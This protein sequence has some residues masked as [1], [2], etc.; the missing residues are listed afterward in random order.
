MIFEEL[1]Q[2]LYPELLENYSQIKQ[3][4]LKK[5]CEQFEQYIFL[6]IAKSDLSE[7]QRIGLLKTLIERSRKDFWVIM[8]MLVEQGLQRYPN[9]LELHILVIKFYILSFQNDKVLNFIQQFPILPLDPH[10]YFLTQTFLQKGNLELVVQYYQE[11]AKSFYYSGNNEF[12][13]TIYR[14]LYP[15]I[16]QY[17]PYLAFNFLHETEKYALGTEIDCKSIK[18]YIENTNTNDVYLLLNN[19]NPE[20]TNKN[21]KQYQKRM[22]LIIKYLSQKNRALPIFKNLDFFLNQCYVLDFCKDNLTVYK[23]LAFFFT[24]KIQ[25]LQQQFPYTLKR[26]K[27]IIL[28]INISRYDRYDFE[29]AIFAL[30]EAFD[31]NIFELKFFAGNTWVVT[32]NMEKFYSFFDKIIIYDTKTFFDLRQ[33][34]FEE[35]ID[36]LLSENVCS[37]ASAYIFFS[38]IAPIQINLWDRVQSFAAPYT[39]YYLSFGKKSAYH[40]WKS[41]KKLPHEKMAHFRHN[42]INPQR[43]QA[44]SK[45]CSV[46]ILPLPENA[47][48]ILFPQV[49]NRLMIED[50]SIIKALLE[51]NPKLYFIALN[52]V[53]ESEE[54]YYYRWKKRMPESMDRIVFLSRVSPGEYLYIIQHAACILGSFMGAHGALTTQTIFAQGQ[55]MVAGYGD[56]FSSCLTKSQ[57][58]ILGVRGLLAENHAHA[59]EICQRLL[60]DPEWKAQKSKEILDNY[61]K[62]NNPKAAAAE[63]QDFLIQA[64]ERA[65]EGKIPEHWDHGLFEDDENYQQ[66]VCEDNE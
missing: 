7:N 11:L 17:M 10:E 46:D 19:W 52:A 35:Q 51:R 56:T 43:N 8:E 40:A 26:K 31:R 15:I 21:F 22:F 6:K 62:L 57:Y 41:D 34:V 53:N 16:F 18:K 54:S 30:F 4:G 29:T 55:P 28:G 47:Q 12:V 3:S 48:Y 63:M 45:S 61:H 64:Y 39:D 32:A 13:E 38:R 49:L 59:V 58:E 60:D 23:A 33:K 5:E 37:I 9:S 25:H 42:Y 36:I 14:G 20:L 65:L 50:D 27:K 44:Q 1:V 24:E 66:A 2:N